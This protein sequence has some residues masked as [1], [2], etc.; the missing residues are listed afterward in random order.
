[1]ADAAAD[2]AAQLA[3]QTLDRVAQARRADS[4]GFAVAKRIAIIQAEE[5]RSRDGKK[6]YAKPMVP[7]HACRSQAG[8]HLGPNSIVQGGTLAA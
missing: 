6:L 8:V 1:M 4:I 7:A 3:P 5:W 2:A